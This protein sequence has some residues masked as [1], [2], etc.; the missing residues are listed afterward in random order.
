MKKL[1]MIG[2][3]L[4]LSPLASADSIPGFYVQGEAG[5]SGTQGAFFFGPAARLSGGYLWAADSHLAYGI[6]SGVAYNKNKLELNLFDD[7][8]TTGYKSINLD[9]LGVLKYSFDSGFNVF[10]KAGANYSHVTTYIEDN[11]GNETDTGTTPD[12]IFPEVALGMGYQFNQNV[13]MDLTA[14]TSFTKA[15]S[16]KN[17]QIGTFNN[18]LMLGLTYHFA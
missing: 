7:T 15:G 16:G 14:S 13:E 18:N 12:Q 11:Q 8:V 17:S 10:G 2:G 3:L 5:A 4:F 6:E 1:L 9:L